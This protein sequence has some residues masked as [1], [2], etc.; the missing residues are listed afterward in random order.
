[1]TIQHILDDSSSGNDRALAVNKREEV[2][3]MLD[4]NETDGTTIASDD[5]EA[6]AKMGERGASL[7]KCQVP[8]CKHPGFLDRG[9]LHYHSKT[10][11]HS[12]P[13]CERPVRKT[14][15]G[16]SLNSADRYTGSSKLTLVPIRSVGALPQPEGSYGRGS[17]DLRRRLR[18][19][20]SSYQGREGVAQRPRRKDVL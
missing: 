14:G 9:G 2:A 1:M 18:L 16:T 17:E 13:G 12:I 15:Y 20:Q 6:E 4:P 5:D 3:A 10:V 8:G 7:F 11:G 19:A